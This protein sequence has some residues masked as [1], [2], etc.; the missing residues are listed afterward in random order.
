MRASARERAREDETTTTAT[1]GGSD[2]LR[3]AATT[4]LTPPPARESARAS[5][6]AGRARCDGTFAEL[7]PSEKKRL[8]ALIQKCV[9]AHDGAGR[10]ERERDAAAAALE[11]E[12]ELRAT[13][14]I[15]RDAAVETART[16]KEELAAAKERA[17]A[18]AATVVRLRERL[19][20]TRGDEERMGM[21]RMSTSASWSKSDDFDVPTPRGTLTLSPVAPE[22]RRREYSVDLLELIE[23]VERESF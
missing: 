22:A 11:R 6:E 12:R 3:A 18:L 14:E 17:A 13:M 5:D 10:A 19:Q 21:A 4:P 16:L 2:V 9:D 7:G 8:A 20:S 15:E 23:S 1:F